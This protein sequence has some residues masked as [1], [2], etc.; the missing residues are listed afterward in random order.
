MLDLYEHNNMQ[1][2]HLNGPY[3]LQMVLNNTLHIAIYLSSTPA[4]I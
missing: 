2:Y 3:S 1:V 4:I